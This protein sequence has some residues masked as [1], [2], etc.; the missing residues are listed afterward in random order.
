[1]KFSF[2]RFFLLCSCS[3]LWASCAFTPLKKSTDIT[4]SIAH[5]LHLD[6]YAPKKI[7][8]TKPVFVFIHGGRWNSG[9]KSQYRFLGNR[10]ARKGIITVIPDYRL[11]PSTAYKG[12][13][14]D[15]A[16]AIQWV[17]ENITSYGGDSNRIFVSGHSAGG[18]LAA[19]VATDNHYFD[20]LK[21]NNPIHGVILIDAFGLDMH[22]FMTN[23]L[24]KKSKTD[25]AMFTNDPENWKRGSPIYH[26][27]EGMP[28]ILLFVGGKTYP[29]ITESNN[30][31]LSA[32]KKYQPDTKLITVKNK[33]HVPMITQFL[34]TGNKAYKQIIS[35]IGK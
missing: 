13:T 4:Y 9:S 33:K 30:G 7:I 23:S 12:M 3:I 8:K 28:P 1:M 35:F 6:V 15:A 17:K 27:R 19:M 11:S 32:V 24:Y 22:Q 25:Y 18:H 2:S 14:M 31:F 29:S 34:Y 26:V 21:I 16:M 5:N 20:S 10:M